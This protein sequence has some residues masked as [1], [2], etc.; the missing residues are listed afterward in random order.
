M[1]R[2]RTTLS[3]SKLMHLSNII[4]RPAYRLSKHRNRKLITSLTSFDVI[5]SMFIYG[6]ERG[7][8]YAMTDKLG[9]TVRVRDSVR[10][11]VSCRVVWAG[12]DR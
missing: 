10:A 12:S 2:D 4:Y 11:R 6:C 7:C 5:R 8:L 3:S 1:L 9:Y